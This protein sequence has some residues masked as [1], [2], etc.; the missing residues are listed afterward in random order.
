MLLA[1]VLSQVVCSS[2]VERIWSAY[3][4]IHNDLRNRLTCQR[5]ADLVYVYVNMRLVDKIQNDDDE[6]YVVWS[7]DSDAEPSDRDGEEEEDVSDGEPVEGDGLDL[8]DSA[9]EEVSTCYVHAMFDC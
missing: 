7:D 6:K 1:K 9:I 2:S 3:G 8:N 4:L 5:A